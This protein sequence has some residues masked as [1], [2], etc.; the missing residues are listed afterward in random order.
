MLFALGR[1]HGASELVGALVECHD[2]VRRFVGLAITL[3]E[4]T[5][6]SPSDVTIGCAMIGRYFTTAFPLHVK[7]EEASILPRL[8]G[9]SPSLDA[10][11]VR[12]HEQHEVHEAMLGRFCDLTGELRRNPLDPRAR[13]ALAS[14]ARPLQLVLVDHLVAEEQIVFPMIREAFSAKDCRL[15]RR[16]IEARRRGSNEAP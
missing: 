13:S 15:V 2:R 3:S 9:R 7:D 14:V 10:A 5:D 16:E 1:R 8:R 6:L 12:M 11:L 4:R